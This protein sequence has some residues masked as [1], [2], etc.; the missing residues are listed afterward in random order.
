MLETCCLFFLYYLTYSVLGWIMEILFA[1]YE[2]H[3]FV[4]RGFLIGPYCSIYGWGC[5]FLILFLDSSKDDPV[6]LILKAIVICSVLEYLT[7]Y[8]MEKLFHARWWDY[9]DKKFNLNGRICLETMIP[10][11]ILACL[12]LYVIQPNLEYYYGLLPNYALI[13]ISAILFTIYLIDNLLSFNIV[14]RIASKINHLEIKDSTEEI[15]K[16]VKEKLKKA[17]YLYRRLIKAFPNF[18]VVLHQVEKKVNEIGS[19]MKKKG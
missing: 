16:L 11:G 6:G 8:I 10:F 1:L 17:P 12:V 4:N 2:E 15:S 13:S 18:H 9:S 5:M 3:K 19:K 7:S 14:F